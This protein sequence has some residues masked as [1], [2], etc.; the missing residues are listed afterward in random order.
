MLRLP[1]PKV[2]TSNAKNIPEKAPMNRAGAKVPPTPPAAK[3]KDVAN[4][5]SRIITKIRINIIHIL[6][7]KLENIL[8]SNNMEQ[9]PLRAALIAS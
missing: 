1:R 8:F 9:S 3:V 7:W 4:A 5:L 2:L 6:F